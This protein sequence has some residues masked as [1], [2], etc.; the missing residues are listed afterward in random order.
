MPICF[1]DWDPQSDAYYVSGVFE[2]VVREVWPP[3]LTMES[4]LEYSKRTPVL[5]SVPFL[6]LRG[7][8]QQRMFCANGESRGQL[9]SRATKAFHMDDI[10]GMP[11]LHFD[12]LVSHYRPNSLSG[13]MM[14]AGTSAILSD[15]MCM[16]SKLRETGVAFLQKHRQKSINKQW[17]DRRFIIERIGGDGGVIMSALWRTTGCWDAR[18]A[19]CARDLLNVA[20]DAPDAPDDDQ[21]SAPGQKKRSSVT[22][23]Y[24]HDD[25]VEAEPPRS[26]PCRSLGSTPPPRS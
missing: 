15:I 3:C 2:C 21:G 18:G 26:R 6:V 14:L 20:P 5:G 1:Y 19:R 25:D 10:S 9:Q 13:K 22:N 4:A 7:K 12:T 17:R 24:P 16:P 23:H 11:M 8:G